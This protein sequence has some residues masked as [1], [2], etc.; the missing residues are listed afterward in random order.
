MG[1]TYRKIELVGTSPDSF[2]EAINNAL[3]TANKDLP[4]LTWFEV[5]E[6][7]GKI[8]GR[9]GLFLPG[10]NEG[11]LYPRL[12]RFNMPDLYRN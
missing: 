12:R 1:H 8:E 6:Q 4:G 9:K 3:A 10:R 5:I 2:E 7:H 11:R